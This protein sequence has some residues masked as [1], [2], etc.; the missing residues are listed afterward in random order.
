[1]NRLDCFN[2][3][4]TMVLHRL[5]EHFPQTA[6]ID[7][8]A[9]QEELARA[10]AICDI[11]GGPGDPGNLVRWTVQF[12]VDE[13]YVRSASPVAGTTIGCILTAK[14]FSA[15]NR[16]LESLTPEAS[17]GARLLAAG[18]LLAPEAAGALITNFLA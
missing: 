14:G 12:L 17:L 6:A 5:L 11:Q 1:M 3:A 16:R 15:L 18:K 10:Y 4:A 2:L 13:G 8:R 7:S 9:I